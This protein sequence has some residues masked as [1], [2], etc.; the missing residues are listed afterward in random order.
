MLEAYLTG[1]EEENLV[2][3]RFEEAQKNYRKNIVPIKNKDF[4][5]MSNLD[6]H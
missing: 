6:H 1:K 5:K 3:I 2:Q 4:L